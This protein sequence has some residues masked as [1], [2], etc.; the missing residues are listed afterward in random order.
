[1]MNG[2]HQ[3]E[4]ANFGFTFIIVLVT[5]TVFSSVVFLID[6]GNNRISEVSVIKQ[7]LANPSG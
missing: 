4:E 2:G 1:M 7:G 6:C 5:A 3:E